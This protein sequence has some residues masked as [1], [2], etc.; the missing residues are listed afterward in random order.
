MESKKALE[1]DLPGL[2][3]ALY[4][5]KA[6]VFAAFAA[7]LALGFAHYKFAKRLYTSRVVFTSEA[8]QSKGGRLGQLAL[9]T[10]SLDLGSESSPYLVHIEK[11]AESRDLTDRMRTMRIGDST[12]LQILVKGKVYKDDTGYSFHS[13]LT[14]LVKLKK[15]PDGLFNLEATT[16]SPEFSRYLADSAFAALDRN[17]DEKKRE[18]TNKRLEFANSLVDKYYDE[19]K[20]ASDRM[21]IFQAEN[22]GASSPAL[23]QRRGFLTMDQKLAEEKYLM[24]FKQREE[25]RVQMDQSQDQLIVIEP[26]YLPLYPTSPTKSKSVVPA[27]ALLCLV[28]ILAIAYLDRKAWIYP[29]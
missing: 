26:A 21:R 19:M 16:D 13:A 12:L 10:G 17:L 25:L 5:R 9:L 20:S 29:A 3:K 11:Y 14:S 28:G 1:I 7:G 8:G 22:L 4:R 18:S 15:D 24:A 27:A 6:W 2:I 23:L